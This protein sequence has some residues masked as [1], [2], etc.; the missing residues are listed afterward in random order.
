MHEVRGEQT[1][2]DISTMQSLRSLRGVCDAMSGMSI[3]PNAN[4]K[5][6]FHIKRFSLKLSISMNNHRVIKSFPFFFSSSNDDHKHLMNLITFLKKKKILSTFI[7]F[8]FLIFCRDAKIFSNSKCK[9]NFK[10]QTTRLKSSSITLNSIYWIIEKLCQFLETHFWIE[11]ISI[12]GEKRCSVWNHESHSLLY[13]KSS[14]FLLNW[15]FETNK[16][17]FLKAHRIKLQKCIDAS[18]ISSLSIPFLKWIPYNKSTFPCFFLAERGSQRAS[19]TDKHTQKAY[20]YRCF[21]KYSSINR[22][23]RHLI[24]TCNLITNF[25]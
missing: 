14:I 11:K 16:K 23:L 15:R 1:H 8:W 25:F 10:K 7:S 4:R 6:K 19:L 9:N 2:S 13:L 24:S 17:K 20:N 12:W 18:P 22:L 3:L 21:L 5:D